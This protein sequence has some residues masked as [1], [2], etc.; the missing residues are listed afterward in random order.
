MIGL[1]RIPIY[2]RGQNGAPTTTPVVSDLAW[3]CA[4]YTQSINAMGGFESMTISLPVL[5]E[6]AL[7][8]LA[9]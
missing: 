1:L 2:Q 7:S 6:E 3:R 4:S 8:M 9:N 5:P